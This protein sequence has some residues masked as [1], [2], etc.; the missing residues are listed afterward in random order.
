VG[1]LC[2]PIIVAG[3]LVMSILVRPAWAADDKALVVFAASSLRTALDAVV[4]DW[5]TASGG[6]ITVSYAGTPAL[7]RQIEQGAP[8]DLFISADAGW[9]ED[10]ARK[11]LVDRR[12][13]HDLLGNRL[14]LITSAE[15][16]QQP[17]NLAA[18][19]DLPGMLRDGR[20][21]VADVAA[22][23]AGR[24]AKASLEAL[25]VWD[26]ISAKL[27]Q[28]ENA[29]AALALV[30]QGEA[31]FGVVYATDAHAERKVK[32]VGIF[33]ETSHTPIVYSAA[34]VAT[35]THSQVRLFLEGLSADG[36]KA[37]FEAEGF[38]VLPRGGG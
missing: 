5:K 1:G 20:L 11:N 14:V 16:V 2:S 35:S 27:A 36:A 29:R 19:F 3:L 12:T 24:Y 7:A 15:A 38:I 25:G 34:V 22:V 26:A 28:A 10:L 18:G 4:S 21:A 31:P 30:A 37:R 17:I 32:V 33:P 13:R 23:P 8:A 6:D 9:M